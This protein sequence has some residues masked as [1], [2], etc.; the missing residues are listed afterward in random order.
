MIIYNNFHE[1]YKS[2]DNDHCLIDN[3]RISVHT[4]HVFQPHNLTFFVVV[5]VVD[6]CFVLCL[7]LCFFVVVVVHVVA[8]C[9]Y[10]CCC[11]C[12]YVCMCVVVV[13]VVVVVCTH[14]IELILGSL[15]LFY[16]AVKA[17]H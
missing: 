12:V 11:V 1:H 14:D 2:E 9:Y 3:R 16:S 13:F 4:K 15:W 8:C 5:G 17:W 6:F 7:F 10:C